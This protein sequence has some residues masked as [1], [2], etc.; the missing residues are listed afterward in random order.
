MYS[1]VDN[2]HVCVLI[3]ELVLI[4]GLVDTQGNQLGLGLV[5]LELPGEEG[6]GGYF[7]RSSTI[8][9]TIQTQESVLM[10]S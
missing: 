1:T 9:L 3:M 10:K 8:H 7:M 5:S 4:E 6:G 2:T